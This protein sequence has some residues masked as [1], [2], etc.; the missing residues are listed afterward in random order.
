[1]LDNLVIGGT[2]GSVFGIANISPNFCVLEDSIHLNEI[3]VL[4]KLCRRYTDKMSYIAGS[5]GLTQNMI[6]LSQIIF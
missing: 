4:S 2:F 5:E 6:L 3:L 1:M